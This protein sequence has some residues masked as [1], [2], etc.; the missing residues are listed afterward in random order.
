MKGFCI[1]R[2][3]PFLGAHSAQFNYQRERVGAYRVLMKF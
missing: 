3:A 1:W 2:S